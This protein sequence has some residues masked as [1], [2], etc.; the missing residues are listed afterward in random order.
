MNGVTKLVRLDLP[1]PT[2]SIYLSDGGIT[3]WGG[4][5]YRDSHATLGAIQQYGE[6]EFGFSN[7]LPE[8][9]FVLAPPS[10]AALTPLQAGAF[11]RSAVRYW[12]AE[13]DTDTGAVV[14]DPHLEFSGR[15]DRIR[16]NFGLRQLSIVV[17]CVPETEALL[18]SDDGNGLSA[19]FHKSVYPG[20]TGHDQA[21]GLVNSV[22]W[23]VESARRG[24]S[25]GG[26]GSGGGGN[27]ENNASDYFDR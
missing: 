27:R 12:V 25:G 9:E 3:V 7:S 11:A 19:E 1:S 10:N 8:W 18:F 24:S 13:Y 20:E 16:Q 6:T 2:G 22:T 23:G 17:S 26:S 4:N 21:T 14:G 5:T 15:L